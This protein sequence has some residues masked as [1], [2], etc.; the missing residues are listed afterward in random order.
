MTTPGHPAH[1]RVGPYPRR[2]PRP[3]RSPHAPRAAALAALGV[4]WPA[5]AGACA[6]CGPGNGRNAFAFYVTTVVLSL[7]PLAL[8][9]GVLLWLWRSGRTFLAGEFQERDDA[10]PATPGPGASA[11][12]K[13]LEAPPEG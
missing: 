13:T 2:A 8:I 9:A 7:L 6:F 1:A 3:R 5:L 12:P 10:P 11:G 4:V